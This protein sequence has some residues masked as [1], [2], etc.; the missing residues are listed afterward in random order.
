MAKGGSR[1]PWVAWRNQGESQGQTGLGCHSFV[2]GRLSDALNVEKWRKGERPALSQHFSAVVTT[3][4]R[5]ALSLKRT[6]GLP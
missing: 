4:A 2:P 5:K 3:A 6:G 1:G